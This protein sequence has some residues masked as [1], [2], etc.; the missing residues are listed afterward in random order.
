MDHRHRFP[1]F[2]IVGAAKSGTTSLHRYLAQHPAVFV[3]AIKEPNFFAYCDRELDLTGPASRRWIRKVVYGRTIR[4]EQQYL[5]LFAEA[6]PQ[7]LVGESSPRYLYYPNAIVNLSLR[8]PSAKLIVLLRDP[9]LRAYSHYR[10]NREYNL[11]PCSRFEDAVALED[12]RV[13][14]GFG[15][16]WH[17]LRVSRYGE[18]LRRLLAHYPREQVFVCTYERLVAAPAA[19]CTEICTFLGISADYDFDFSKRHKVTRPYRGDVGLLLYHPNLTLAG[20]VARRIVPFPIQRRIKSGIDFLDRKR[21]PVPLD[22]ATYHQLRA[23]MTEDI[24]TLTALTDLDISPWR[25]RARSS[26]A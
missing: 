15:W 12:Q 2:F 26:A 13:A 18:Q 14:K 21:P 5:S 3:P 11:E 22:T 24:E 16:D 17:Y 6:K 23:G 8:V 9:V 10:M 25:S 1:D 20:R 19:V 7:Q 4:D